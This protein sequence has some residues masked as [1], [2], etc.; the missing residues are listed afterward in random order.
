ML[1]IRITLEDCGL[2]FSPARYGPVG[3][4]ILINQVKHSY[5]SHISLRF[6]PEEHSIRNSICGFKQPIALFTHIINVIATEKKSEFKFRSGQIGSGQVRSIRMG[7]EG[8]FPWEITTF[9]AIQI[10][11]SKEGI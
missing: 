5:L 9:K 3:D 1:L 7:R 10:M 8:T 4:E 11:P 6:R 2:F